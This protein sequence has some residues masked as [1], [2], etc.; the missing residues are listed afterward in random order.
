MGTADAE[1]FHPDTLADWHDWLAANH[2]R[3]EGVW[4]VA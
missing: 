1:R 2:T 3:P 4:I